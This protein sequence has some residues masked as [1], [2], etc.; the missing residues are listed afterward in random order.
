MGD[1]GWSL[2]VV[3]GRQAGRSY[4]LA[5][6]EVVLGN[7]PADASGIDLAEQEGDT[8]RRM[9]A[10]QAVVA[11]TPA[12]L[13]VRDLDSPGGTFVNRQRVLP[14]QLLPL[15]AGDVLQLGGVQLK[16]VAKANGQPSTAP[17]AVPTQPFVLKNGTVCRTWD[18][19]LR[20]AAQRW[21]DLRDELTSGRIS[22]WL[23]AVGRPDLVAHRPSEGSADEHLDAWLARL[24]TSSPARPELDVH[25]SHLVVRVTPGGGTIARSVQVANVGHRLLH[26]RAQVEPSGTGWARVASAFAGRTHAV[27][28][29]LD[30][31]IEIDVPAT[32]RSPLRTT[33]RIDGDGG[34]KL[35]ELVLEA[36]T[37]AEPMAAAPSR[38]GPSPLD[39]MA[40]IPPATRFVAYISLAIVI[41]LAAGA[42]SG[43]MGTD[44]AG[45]DLLRVALLFAVA[46][47]LTGAILAGR[48]SGI[49]AVGYVAA[50]AAIAG[51]AVAA[52]FVATC[53]II[54]PVLGGWS[55]SILAIAF[56][57][58][59]IGAAKAAASLW[60]APYRKPS[61]SPTP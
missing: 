13:L 36:R 40:R 1:N 54:E 10:R 49:D 12:G 8:P 50:S 7:A 3:K 26:V 14:G 23:T 33:L 60:I 11:A 34:T 16:V 35:V 20:V 24:P 31:P 17:A 46:F 6:P 32:L 51:C 4:A 48:R 19:F 21:G 9:A 27:V 56:L 52:L 15:R 39:R 22:V 28:D 18:D 45:L 55:H 47:G 37:A 44:A 38:V 61:A 41:R 59:A 30:I 29:S 2:E 43:S 5:G 58:A 57:W 53:R 42:I 25:P